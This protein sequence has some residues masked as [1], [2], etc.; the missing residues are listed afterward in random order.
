MKNLHLSNVTLMALVASC[1]IQVGA[2]LFAV[3]MIASTVVEA[4]PRSFAIL[5]GE[6]GY[7]SQAFWAVVP[8]ITLLLFVLALIANWRTAR[9]NLLLA[10]LGLFVLAGLLAI[11]FLGPT[12]DAMIA[13][14]F[15]D[16]IDPVLKSQASTWLMMDWAV[17][18]LGLV[19]GWLLLIA[20]MRPVTSHDPQLTKQ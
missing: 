10:A 17:W 4:P 9:R 19:A 6:Y 12:F 5:Q 11:F 7:D 15:S 3:S 18:G 8:N 2:Q 1:F 13:R 20:L 16:E 14:G